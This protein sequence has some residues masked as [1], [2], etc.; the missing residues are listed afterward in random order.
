MIS[1]MEK[2]KVVLVFFYLIVFFSTDSFAEPDENDVLAVM[3]KAADFMVNTVSYRGGYV[4][5]YS[6]DLSEQWGE[7]TARKSQ[8]WVQPP[9]TPTVGQMYLDAYKTTA[10]PDYL[11]Y[12]ELCKRGGD[13]VKARTQLKKAIEIFKK[14]NA[15]GWVE[16]AEKD[17]ARC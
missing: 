3:K 17:L 10:D 12:A 6:E 1:I 5:I 9:G 8:I 2:Y 14:C 4:Y 11:T 16:K 7:I 13:L 15:D